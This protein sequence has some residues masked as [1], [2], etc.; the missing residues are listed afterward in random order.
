METTVRRLLTYLLAP[1]AALALMTP[2]LAQERAVVVS[3]APT[4]TAGETR[5]LTMNTSGELRVTGA[6]G[7]GG[8][9]HR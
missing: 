9:S 6:G 5:P 7:G 8:V 2:A 1:L 3:S 4:F